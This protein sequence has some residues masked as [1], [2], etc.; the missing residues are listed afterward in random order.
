MLRWYSS[1][2]KFSKIRPTASFRI[3]WRASSDVISSST[4]VLSFSLRSGLSMIYSGGGLATGIRLRNSLARLGYFLTEIV[5][6]LSSETLSDMLT[7]QRN[8][9]SINFSIVHNSGC[10][11]FKF[12]RICSRGISLLMMNLGLQLAHTLRLIS[13]LWPTEILISSSAVAKHPS[14]SHICL[15]GPKDKVGLDIGD[16][17]SYESCDSLDLGV[18]IPWSS[19]SL[20]FFISFLPPLYHTLSLN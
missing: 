11:Q 6:P 9:S 5:S 15:L 7:K 8:N 19:G 17:L 2:S 20:I 16:N 10:N 4:S 1:E 18:S 3:C 14:A 13:P 12:P